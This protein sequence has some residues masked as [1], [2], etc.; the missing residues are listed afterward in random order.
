MLRLKQ[1]MDELKI[2]QQE[3]VKYSGWS[4]TQVS[5]TFKTGKLPADSAKFAGSVVLF[6]CEARPEIEA[7]VAEQGLIVENLLD[8]LD[9]S[10]APPAP[11]LE[12]CLCEIAG[13]AMLA[14][15]T[16]RSMVIDLARACDL[17]RRRLVD[18]VGPDAPYMVKIEGE[19]S[20]LLRQA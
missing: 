5:L 9:D 12:R 2:P 3:F 17:L 13:R 15:A 8:N 20:K 7:W 1:A 10:A 11:D 4:K 18:L 16:S 19:V 6:A 14:N